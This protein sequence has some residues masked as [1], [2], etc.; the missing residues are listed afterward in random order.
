MMPC[1]EAW[2]EEF[3]IWEKA[4]SWVPASERKGW[5]S[6]LGEARRFCALQAPRV[7][8][9]ESWRCK[10]SHH[11]KIVSLSPHVEKPLRKRWIKFREF[12]IFRISMFMNN[13]ERFSASWTLWMLQKLLTKIINHT[14][15]WRCRINLILSKSYLLDLA[16]RTTTKSTVLDLTGLA[17][18]SRFLQ[19]EQN[20]ISHLVTELL[21]TVPSPF[22]E[23]I[24]LVASSA[25]WLSSNS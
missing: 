13:Y 3:G 14:W 24:F 18:S 7:G 15:L 5:D 8:W 17:W 21:S 2:T 19:L 23:Q 12:C 1:P 11:R 16:R 25:F 10:S 6:E 20:V 22:V 4:V 9:V